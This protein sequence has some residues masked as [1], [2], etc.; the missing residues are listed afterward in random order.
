[1]LKPAQLYED[2]LK[3]KMINCWYDERYK[4]YS[5]WWGDE[6]KGL[7]DNYYDEHH[8]VSVDKND[9]IIGYISYKIN[10]GSMSADR[11]GII[12]FDIG[13]LTFGKDLYTA[14]KN[15]FKIYHMNRIEWSV[16]ADN[17]IL[18]SY[19]RFAEKHGGV[20]CAHKRQVSK[21]FD[22]K[23]HDMISFEIMADDFRE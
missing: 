16:V 18:K 2:K 15:L 23:M 11:F 22:G 9:K 6:W 19:K 8:F 3:E 14:I 12:N 7:P 13:N 21:L 1:M 10:W 5:G 17:P 4:Y 20:K